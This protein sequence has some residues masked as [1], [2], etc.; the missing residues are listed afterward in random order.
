M[1]EQAVAVIRTEDAGV[2]HEGVLEA[3]GHRGTQTDYRLQSLPGGPPTYGA[4]Q[5]AAAC[6]RCSVNHDQNSL[7]ATSSP[8]PR[9]GSHVAN[10]M[11]SVA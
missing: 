3:N 4:H 5:L 10:E 6:A 1:N 11:Y 7:N 2:S 8:A 9:S